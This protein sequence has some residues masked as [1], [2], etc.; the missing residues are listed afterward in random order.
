MNP[1]MRILPL[2][3]ANGLNGGRIE[4]RATSPYDEKLSL[5][6]ATDLHG[7]CPQCHIGYRLGRE[8]FSLPT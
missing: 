3:S 8:L 2:L 7:S 6:S 4:V 5:K 1:R